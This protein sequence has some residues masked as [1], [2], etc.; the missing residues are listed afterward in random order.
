MK[1]IPLTQGKFALVDDEDYEG[2]NQWKWRVNKNHNNYYA[3][4]TQHHGEGIREEIIMARLLM[5]APKRMQ[6]DHI[7]GNGLDNRKENLRVVTHQQNA[8]NTKKR[9]GSSIYKGVRWFA[10][11]NQWFVQICK[12][13]KVLYIGLFDNEQ[14]GAMAYDIWAKDLFGEY[15]RLNFPQAIHH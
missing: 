14:H 15:A 7:N 4:R 1:Y 6:I 12:D 11:T 10:Q 5:E 13:C 3:V 2:L 9:K 8:W